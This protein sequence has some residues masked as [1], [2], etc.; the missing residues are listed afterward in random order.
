MEIMVSNG[1]KVCHDELLEMA[2]EA[3]I[4]VDKDQQKLF[5]DQFEIF[6]TIRQM[7]GAATSKQSTLGPLFL[8]RVGT[9]ALDKRTWWA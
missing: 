1:L 6:E 7:N 3:E 2:V 9:F 8:R 5:L 4:K